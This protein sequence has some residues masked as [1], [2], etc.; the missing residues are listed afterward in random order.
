MSPDQFV[1]YNYNFLL[2]LHLCWCKNVKKLY[3]WW[4][5]KSQI[6][7]LLSIPFPVLLLSSF[8]PPSFLQA[9]NF[10]SLVSTHTHSLWFLRSNFP[11]QW[12]PKMPSMARPTGQG[13]PTKTWQSWKWTTCITWDSIPQWTSKVRA[14]YYYNLKELLT[15]G[16]WTPEFW[17]ATWQLLL[18][19]SL[20]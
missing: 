12:R 1:L 9:S 3:R 19:C 18:G 5:K 2:L 16:W 4:K 8:C 6:G 10:D 15:V 17:P 7:I 11:E 14:K 13:Q 20:V